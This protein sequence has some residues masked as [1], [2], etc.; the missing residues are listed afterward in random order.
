MLKLEVTVVDRGVG[1]VTA[2]V[3][4][5]EGMILGNVTAPVVEGATFD[6][7]GAVIRAAVEKAICKLAEPEGDRG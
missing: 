5:F 4:D 3:E 1:W 2:T 6:T 7:Q